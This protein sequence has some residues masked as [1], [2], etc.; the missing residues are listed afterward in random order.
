MARKREIEKV[1]SWKA[2]GSR[3][4][5]RRGWNGYAIIVGSKRKD[6]CAASRAKSLLSIFLYDFAAFSPS[7]CPPASPPASSVP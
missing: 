7:P 4:Q 6:K 2:N 3:G 1:E 5:S